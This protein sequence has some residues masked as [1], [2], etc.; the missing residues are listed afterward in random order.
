MKECI[1]PFH[2][3]RR[4]IAE[5]FL[6]PGFS[7]HKLGLRA[8]KGESDSRKEQYNRLEH[9]AF[10]RSRGGHFSLFSVSRK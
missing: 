3:I 9:A 10:L 7:L 5:I 6:H 8:K 1:R 4:I 2:K